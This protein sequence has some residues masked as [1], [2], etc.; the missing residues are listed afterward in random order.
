MVAMMALLR[1]FAVLTLCSQLCGCVGPTAIRYSRNLYN[2]AYRETNDQEILLNIVRLRYA[3][4]PVFIDL[5]NITS[6]FQVSG[7]G[8][9]TGGVDGAGPGPTRL[10]MGELFLK[11]APT[12]SYTPRSGQQVGKRL[13][14]ALRSDLLASISPGGDMRLFMLAAI[15]SF[16]GIRN[17][18]L[19]TSI[20]PT[21]RDDN[22]LFEHVVDLICCLQE[23]GA[24]EFRLVK[25]E[26]ERSGPIDASKIRP[27]DMVEAARSDMEFRVEGDSALLIKREAALAMVVRDNESE[28]PEMLELANILG[29]EAG[30]QVYR[31]ETQEYDELETDELPP[32]LGSDTL[33]LNMRSLWQLMVFLSKG[34]HVP[35]QHV[36]RGLIDDNPTAPDG[37]PLTAGVMRVCSRKHRP[38][39]V[40][41]AVKYR[42]FWFYVAEDD[43]ATR[44]MISLLELILELQE[45]E[46]AREG[47]LLTLPVG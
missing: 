22:E 11:D 3:D 44:S 25:F 14:T 45:S 33:S 8:A 26:D 34:V 5:P 16:N 23:R 40:D 12:L 24:I 35:S 32:A 41:V 10:G 7:M 36:E 4:S 13:L 29:L 27:R 19:S 42:G 9:G 31:I 15:D 1:T 17:A 38:K 18:P 21:A 6:Q 28:S 2:E 39:H 30:R 43:I 20:Y 46:S 37:S 47:P